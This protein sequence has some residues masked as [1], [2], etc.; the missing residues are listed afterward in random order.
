MRSQNMERHNR[1]W[2]LLQRHASDPRSGNL[3]RNQLALNFGVS[4][5]TLHTVC[6]SF[7]GL[8]VGAYIRQQRLRLA[9]D[10]LQRARPATTTVTAVAMFCGFCDLGR[11]AG[12][13]R[14]FHG[15]LPSLVLRQA[16]DPTSLLSASSSSE[17]ELPQF[18]AGLKTRRVR[19][20]A[21]PR[22]YGEPEASVC[23]AIATSGDQ[24]TPS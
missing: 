9:F 10:M 12:A 13:F 20:G 1:V 17:S 19:K 18:L 23:A 7:A 2:Q 24:T 21:T 14:D 6:Y 16:V 3:T 11:F 4:P 15:Q 22:S 5:R 8:S